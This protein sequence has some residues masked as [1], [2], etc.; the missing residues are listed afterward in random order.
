MG[1]VTALDSA[2]V[3]E[4]AVGRFTGITLTPPT[5]GLALELVRPVLGKRVGL[6]LVCLLPRLVLC[7][8]PFPR[9]LFPI[10]APFPLA[11]PFTLEQLFQ[12]WREFGLRGSPLEKGSGYHF[13]P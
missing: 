1:L 7:L 2:D 6:R 3:C 13:G 4:F 5:D 9:L 12:G 8:L 10:L 11:F